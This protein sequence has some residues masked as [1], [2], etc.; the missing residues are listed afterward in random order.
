M[1]W[2][3]GVIGVDLTPPTREGFIMLL[4]PEDWYN[5]G[6]NSLALKF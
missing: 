1:G 3:E 5:K 2:K 4:S 6:H